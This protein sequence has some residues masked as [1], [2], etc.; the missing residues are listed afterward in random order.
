MCAAFAL[1]T[2]RSAYSFLAVPLQV[3]LVLR[4]ILVV[5]IVSRLAEG[6]H[7]ERERGVLHLELLGAHPQAL[8]LGAV[9]VECL[10]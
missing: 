7:V 9:L 5:T 6:L 2:S 8:M 1:E 10:M 3:A 4:Q